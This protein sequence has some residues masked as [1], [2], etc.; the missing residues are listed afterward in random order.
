MAVNSVFCWRKQHRMCEHV[1]ACD[2]ACHARLRARVCVCVGALCVWVCVRLCPCSHVR[3]CTC[4]RL[5]VC[6]YNAHPRTPIAMHV[7]ARQ[8]VC[9][10]WCVW[11]YMYVD[12]CLAD[13]F[14]LWWQA[15]GNTY[16]SLCSTSS[17][18]RLLYAHCFLSTNRLL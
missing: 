3:V 2:Y 9:V 4:G 7:C 17:T 15:I 1:C 5:G 18:S 16:A 11:E 8:C 13:C 14:P 6:A 10:A 12:E